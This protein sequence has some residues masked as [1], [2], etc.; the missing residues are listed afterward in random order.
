MLAPH[1][2]EAEFRASSLDSES[3]E[4]PQQPLE[5][6]EQEARPRRDPTDAA[7]GTLA[8]IDELENLE[9]ALELAHEAGLSTVGG[10]ALPALR[11]RLR[12]HY[13]GVGRPAGD[14][15]ADWTEYWS[16]EHGH[17]YWQN[18]ATGKSV[19]SQPLE[20]PS[21]VSQRAMGDNVILQSC[22]LS[23]AGI[24]GHS[25][26]IYAVALFSLLSFSAEMKVSPNSSHKRWCRR[27]CTTRSRQRRAPTS[28]W[29]G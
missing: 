21:L 25:L 11:A 9:D 23:L 13:G 7:T 22:A 4:A 15:A 26:G 5:G 27:R 8:V 3:F 1:S 6:A 14:L 10:E 2:F 18:N 12:A 20:A 28:G 19:W 29:S 17:K 16:E 24:V